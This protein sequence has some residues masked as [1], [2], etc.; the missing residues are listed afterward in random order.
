MNVFTAGQPHSS[1]G[2]GF[3]ELFAPFAARSHLF[4]LAA[5]TDTLAF[6]WHYM[7]HSATGPVF[8][9][10]SRKAAPHVFDVEYAK[11]QVALTYSRGGFPALAWRVVTFFVGATARRA[12]SATMTL[13]FKAGPWPWSV[14]D[15]A[16]RGALAPACPGL[17]TPP[18]G[19]SSPLQRTSSLGGFA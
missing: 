17:T 2:P 10:C 13:V 15:L 1:S 18:V 11:C 7:W 3:R 8:H 5:L 19:L 4:E 14:S 9:V 16:G 12:S 6:R